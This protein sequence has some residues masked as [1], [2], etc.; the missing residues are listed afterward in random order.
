MNLPKSPTT[1]GQMCTPHIESL[2]W[3][4]EEGGGRSCQW[5][6]AEHTTHNIGQ[7]RDGD[8]DSTKSAAG[9]LSICSKLGGTQ[10]GPGGPGSFRLSFA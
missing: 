2:G 9:S 8:D 6:R 4:K 1:P 3:L 7:Q 5:K 10:A